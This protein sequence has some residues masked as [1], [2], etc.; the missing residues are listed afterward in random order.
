MKSNFVILLVATM[1]ITG[2]SNIIAA[3]QNH[4][5]KTNTLDS[6]DVIK[7]FKNFFKSGDYYFG[8]QPTLEAINWLKSE[9]VKLFINL[10]T[11]EENKKFTSTAFN[12][13]NLLK[14]YG[15]KYISIPVSYPDSY[16]PKTLK[17]FISALTEY[18]GKV[19]IHCA[20]G[21]RVRYFFMAY[22]IESKGYSLNDAI[23]FVKQM[24]YSF[25]LENLL[26]KEIYMTLNEKNN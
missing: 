18:E 13:E 23:A 19:F 4:K 11:E 21:G 6:V 9:G 10:R 2:T 12:E 24:K 16:N 15:I 14:E 20:S 5:E 25:L 26:G 1:L 17:K 3:K 22:L 7:E 8:G